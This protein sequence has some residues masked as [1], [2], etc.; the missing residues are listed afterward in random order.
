MVE[1]RSYC[2]P[3]VSMQHVWT[4]GGFTPC[5]F[6]TLVPSVLGT[7]AVFLGTL[8][9][10]CYT[11]YGTRM[12]PRFLPRSRLYKLQLALSILLGLQALVWM[13]FR[14]VQDELVVG[15]VLLCGWLYALA[16]TW[17]TALLRLERK[18]VLVRDRTRG[19]SAVLLLFWTVAFISENLAFVSWQSPRWWWGLENPEQMVSMGWRNIITGGCNISIS[20]LFLQC[21]WKA[22]TIHLPRH[23]SASVHSGS[24]F[25]HLLD[26]L[27]C[28]HNNIKPEQRL[29]FRENVMFCSALSKIISS[30]SASFLKVILYDHNY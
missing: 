19:H 13:I 1:L 25:E 12:E 27:K 26:G 16:W 5:F 15:Y 18:R 9:C 10:V 21:C 20:F 28:S 2:E 4:E 7:L 14:V 17:A 8:H 3:D 11:H 24:V 30:F 6:F 22:H 23:L 29:C